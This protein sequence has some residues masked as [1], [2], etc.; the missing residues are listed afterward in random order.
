M[1]NGNG[2]RKVAHLG[3]CDLSLFY[4]ATKGMER[5]VNSNRR[6]VGAGGGL[7]S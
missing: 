3:G 6:L 7:K 1:I 5:G 2:K 4:R